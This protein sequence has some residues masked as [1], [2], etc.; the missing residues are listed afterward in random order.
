MNLKKGTILE[1]IWD[2]AKHPSVKHASHQYAAKAGALAIVEE[3]Y[4]DSD[5]SYVQVRW[6]EETKFL[7]GNQKDGCYEITDFIVK[8]QAQVDDEQITVLMKHIGYNV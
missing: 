3:D 2:S 5:G 8:K 4:Y 7:S 1:W 6:L